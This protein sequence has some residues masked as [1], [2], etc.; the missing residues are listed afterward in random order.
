MNVSVFGSWAR[1]RVW[2]RVF[3][4]LAQ[5]T[6]NY[7]I[8]VAGPVLPSFA[9]PLNVTFIH[10]DPDPGP[11]VCAQ[12][13]SKRCRGE[14]MLVFN[15]DY[16][17]SPYALD[18]AYDAYVRARDYKCMIHLI[19]GTGPLDNRIASVL[20]QIVIP[21]SEHRW[22]FALWSRQVFLELGGFDRRCSV[23]AYEA[24]FMLRVYSQGGRYVYASE[25]YILEDTSVAQGV[26]AWNRD[27]C[28][29]TNAV[30]YA[31]WMSN[32]IRHGG[33]VLRKPR[34]SFEPID[35]AVNVCVRDILVGG[36]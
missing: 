22:G 28:E 9:L 3:D 14:T 36:Q 4:N 33:Y 17:L 11:A 27:G 21:G 19:P 5:N 12:L 16:V 15:D 6:I 34:T 31:R 10:C 18:Y 24:D 13:A 35:D 7:E 32:G 1:P 2:S 25:A 29:E 26:Y 30:V 8:V 23:G 20:D